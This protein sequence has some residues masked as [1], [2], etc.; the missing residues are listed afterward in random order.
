MLAYE[1]VEGKSLDRLDPAD[2]TDEVVAAIWQQVTMMRVHRIAHRDL[3]LANIFL[4]AD[5]ESG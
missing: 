2:V 3:R 4:G 1:A 5:G